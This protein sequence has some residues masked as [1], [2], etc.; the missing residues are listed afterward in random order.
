MSQ[1]CLNWSMGIWLEQLEPFLFSILFSC[2]VGGTC[3]LQETL[4]NYR[5]D[6]VSGWGGRHCQEV[7]NCASNPCNNGAVCTSTAQG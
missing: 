5:C 6:C 2:I 1:L 4:A 3:L 7:D